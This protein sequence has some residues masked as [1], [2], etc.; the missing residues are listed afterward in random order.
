MSN[1]LFNTFISAM[2]WAII[3]VSSRA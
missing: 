3:K 2:S 1:V